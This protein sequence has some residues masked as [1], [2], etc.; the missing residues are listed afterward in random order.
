MRFL[1]LSVDYEIFGNGTGDVRQ[2]IVAPTARLARLCRKYAVPLTVFFEAE[3]YLAFV[4][5]AQALRALLGYDPAQLMRE[6]AHS[7]VAEGHDVQLH[8]HPEWYGA[9]FRD[10]GW[11]LR[12]EAQTVD[13]LFGSQPEVDRYLAERKTV[14]EDLLA[15]PQSRPRVRAYRAGA[16]CAQPGTRLLA[17]L[18]KNGVT[19]DSSVV[20]G[21]HRTNE[22]ARFDYRHC[23]AGKAMWRVRTDVAVEDAGGPLWEVPIGSVPR[24]RFALL[25]PARL[26]AKFSRN[27]PRAAQAQLL[28]EQGVHGNPFA[29]ARLLWQRVPVKLD[30]HN[31]SPRKLMRWVHS[32]PA[33][34]GGAKDLVV[35]IWHTKEHIVD[36][37]F[38][39]L[40]GSIARDPALRVVTFDWLATQLVSP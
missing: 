24:R 38:E 31:V 16:F 27:V 13:S 26:R 6:Q 35:L 15:H 23:P 2:H 40:L 37:P 11:R 19:I 39:Q 5:H 12:P 29:V 9:T 32:L 10:G 34:A 18:A 7:L 4:R 36:R 28:N 21:L 25:S 33:N 30:F 3:E 20:R 1:I 14:L 8:L 17:A 22:H